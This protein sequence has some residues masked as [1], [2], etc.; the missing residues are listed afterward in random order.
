[1]PNYLHGVETITLSKGPVPVQVVK[2][3]V[4]ALVGI[5]PTE[6]NKN[7]LTLVQSD[8]DAASFGKTVPGFNIPQSLKH[9][10]AQGFGTVLVVNTFDLATNSA[11]VTREVQTIT[12]GKTKLAYAPLDTVVLEDGSDVA[13]SWVKDTDYT[14]DEFGN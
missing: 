9:I 12:N 7:V 3:A 10:F 6:Y 8:T 11:Q 5:A 4:I 1:M 13:V 2:S 14:L